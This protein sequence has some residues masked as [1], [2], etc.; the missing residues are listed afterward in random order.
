M[1]EVYGE[2]G[3]LMS[4]YCTVPSDERREGE[5]LWVVGGWGLFE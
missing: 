3:G 2:T 5:S 4:I 1:F